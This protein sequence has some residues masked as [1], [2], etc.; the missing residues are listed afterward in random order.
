MQNPLQSLTTQV[1]E[2]ARRNFDAFLPWS[3]LA[4]LGRGGELAAQHPAFADN[5]QHGARDSA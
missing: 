4:G 5:A 2:I 3:P 1:V